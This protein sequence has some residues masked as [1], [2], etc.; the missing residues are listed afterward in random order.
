MRAL[1]PEASVIGSL[2]VAA[3][4][5]GC[6]RLPARAA[7]L[8]AMVWWTH[9]SL[10]CQEF[11]AVFALACL[12]ALASD[13]MTLYELLPPETH[14][15][16]ITSTQPQRRFGGTISP[17]SPQLPT[18]EICAIFSTSAVNLGERVR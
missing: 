13:E 8:L 14:Q 11:C 12:P 6:G 4:Q 15:F 5:T 1:C 3:P 2:G 7:E 16:A 9:A 10:C 17:Q 18:H